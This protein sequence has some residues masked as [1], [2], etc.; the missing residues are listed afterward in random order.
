MSVAFEVSP[1]PSEKVRLPSVSSPL[2]VWSPEN[3]NGNGCD[4]M[5]MSG[6]FFFYVKINII[7]QMR[8]KETK[9]MFGWSIAEEED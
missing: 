3:N 8:K 2:N 7:K 4:Q 1:S 6:I 9:K 5:K